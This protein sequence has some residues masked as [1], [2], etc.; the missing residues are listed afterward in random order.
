MVPGEGPEHAPL[1]G[2]PFADRPTGCSTGPLWKP[3]STARAI[4][5]TNAVKN[6]KFEQRSKRPLRKRLNAYKIK[7]RKWCNDIER[8]LMK[9]KLAAHS[10]MGKP[11]SHQ[12]PTL[13]DLVAR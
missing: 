4:F 1:T 2:H 13:R 9:P 5:V 11:V 8:A 3:V 10:L 6:F 7:R 12:S